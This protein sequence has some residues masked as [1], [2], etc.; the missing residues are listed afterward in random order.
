MLPTGQKLYEKHGAKQ[1]GVWVTETGVM[2]KIVRL[3]EWPSLTKRME[4]LTNR[5]TDP[6]EMAYFEKCRHYYTQ[7]NTFICREDSHVPM[8]KFC[9]TRPVLIKR[10]TPRKSDPMTTMKIRSMINDKVKVMGEDYEITAFLHPIFYSD[11]CLFTL[12]QMKEGYNLD[13]LMKN[14]VG[15]MRNPENFNRLEECNDAFVKCRC[16]IMMPIQ[17]D[18]LPSCW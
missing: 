4:C 1:L 3:V 8:G 13:R 6:E 14:Y 10:F 2:N 15:Y 17:F 5:W 16:V 7:V 9:P 11:R 18:K 12:W